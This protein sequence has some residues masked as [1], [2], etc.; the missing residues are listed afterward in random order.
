M[1]HGPPR[2]CTSF[3][4]LLFL[5]AC[6][7]G[8][9]DGSARDPASGLPPGASDQPEAVSLLGEPLFRP[10]LDPAAAA[11]MDAQLDSA[12]ADHEAAGGPDALIWLGR[13][14]AYPG[15]YREA[16]AAF[17]EGIDRYPD[18][19]RFYRHRGHRYI[20]VREL[21]RAIDD[22]ERAAQMVADRPDEIEPDGQP[23]PAGIP[24][25]TLNTNI[26]Y[27]LGLARY[28]QA[29]FEAAARAFR[30][31]LDIAPND[32]MRVAMADWLWLSLMRTGQTDEAD[33]L[34]ATIPEEMELLENHS[35]HRRLLR[36]QSRRADGDLIREPHGHDGDDD[37]EPSALEVATLGYGAGAWHLIQGDT[38]RAL[39]L[40]RQV[41]E[42]GS[43][44][45]FG[46]IAAEAEIARLDRAPPADRE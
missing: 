39:Q 41:R 23:N 30:T 18:D 44:A 4:L 33:A 17:S 16:I 37:V 1:Q 15:R 10:D 6:A 38:S 11:R 22:F 7:P 45:A 46:F 32:D 12:R 28:L 21:D 24:L 34:L 29:D 25:S 9:D 3:L 2:P 27:H 19:P 13:R 42:T 14:L 8:D 36:Y 5:A 40:F 35:Y 31:G 26:W 43:W 20:T